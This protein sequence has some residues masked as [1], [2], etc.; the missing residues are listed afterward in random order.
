MKDVSQESTLAYCA[1]VRRGGPVMLLC[2]KDS[3][4]S[5]RRFA[6]ARKNT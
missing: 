1:Q 3:E 6:D 5:Q 4:I 2:L